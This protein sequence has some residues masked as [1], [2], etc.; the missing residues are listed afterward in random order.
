MKQQSAPARPLFDLVESIR[1]RA[2]WTKTRLSE[3]TGVPRTTIERWRD[4]PRSPLPETVTKVADALCINR[5][6]ALHAAGILEEDPAAT[7]QR[8]Q[9][10]AE[11]RARLAEVAAISEGIERRLAELEGRDERPKTG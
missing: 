7:E 2:G 6:E 1:V 3:M 4:Q 10:V 5:D 11:L 8:G 9:T